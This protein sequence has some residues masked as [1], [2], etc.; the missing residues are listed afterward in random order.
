MI[1]H[2]TG[3][4]P[5]KGF[6]AIKV[7]ATIGSTSFTTSIFPEKEG[8]FL[9]PVKASVRKKEPVIPGTTLEVDLEFVEL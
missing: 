6:G 8:T 5:R 1:K 7:N 3:H 9:L 2:I 4:L